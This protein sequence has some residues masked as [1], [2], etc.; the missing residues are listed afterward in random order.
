MGYRTESH[1]KMNRVQLLNRGNMS[2][3]DMLDKID[4][5]AETPLERI[6]L[7]RFE[8]IKEQKREDRS[9][10]DERYYQNF[11]THDTMIDAEHPPSVEMMQGEAYKEC[12]DCGYSR[13]FA[14]ET[15]N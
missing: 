10:E 6:D 7:P 3:D 9:R 2:I 8:R 4:A 11:C 1:D 5:L 15:I 12:A 13:T 14:I